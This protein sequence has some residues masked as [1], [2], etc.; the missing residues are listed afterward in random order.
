[1]VFFMSTG[2]LR[3][4]IQTKLSD[5]FPNLKKNDFKDLCLREQLSKKTAHAES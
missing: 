1:M 5:L 3:D 4:E 2:Q